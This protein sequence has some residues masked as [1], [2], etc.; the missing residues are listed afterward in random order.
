MVSLLGSILETI[1]RLLEVDVV[2]Q[3][4]QW[5]VKEMKV[6]VPFSCLP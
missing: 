1:E 6:G 5:V 3:E 4:F 2:L